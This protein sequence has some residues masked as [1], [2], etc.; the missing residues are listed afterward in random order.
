M[1]VLDHNLTHALWHDPMFWECVP[2]FEHYR[3]EA[4]QVTAQANIVQS[5]LKVKH[6]LLYTR[7]LQLLH[8]WATDNPE[9]I[10][11]LVAYIQKKRYPCLEDIALPLVPSQQNQ[12]FL[13]RK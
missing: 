8:E 4:E 5:S 2:S 11:Q 12:V 3:E 6:S 10:K 7:W 1:L 9:A 13:F